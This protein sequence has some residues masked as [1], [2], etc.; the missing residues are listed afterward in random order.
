MNEKY[1]GVFSQFHQVK[2]FFSLKSGASVGYPYDRMDV[3]EEI[4]LADAVPVWPKQIHK[5]HIEAIVEKPQRPLKLADTDGLITN[6]RGV[7]LTTVHADCLPVYFFDPAKEAI[8]LV[9]AGWRG[10]VAG[11]APKAVKKMGAEFGSRSEDIFVYIGSGI[12][13]CCFETGVEVY[14][15]FQEAWPFIDE[16]AG[17]MAERASGKTSDQMAERVSVKS[18]GKPQDARPASMFF[19]PSDQ[20]PSSL[21]EQ[22]LNQAPGKLYA[23]K[24]HIDLKAINKRQLMDIGVKPEHIEVSRH[25]TYCEPE[26][27]CSYRRE[28]GTYQRMGAGLCLV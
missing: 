1:I 23:E 8:G 4:G 11:I 26:L 19:K 22:A 2:G 24:Y 21:P 5:G 12:S 25:C 18:Q 14:Q 28:G 20:R 16:A 27:F 6:V 9:H 13:K 7:L 3:F 17:Q 10:T 15:A